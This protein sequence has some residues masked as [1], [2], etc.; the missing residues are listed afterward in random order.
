[1]IVF[2]RVHTPRRYNGIL[3]DN[4]GIIDADNIAFSGMG[5]RLSGL[6]TSSDP[7]RSFSSND[8]DAHSPATFTEYK[9]ICTTD[10]TGT[11]PQL[12]TSSCNAQ[13]SLIYASTPTASH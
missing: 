1:M 8:S 6:H 3:V 4:T 11:L 13:C 5:A 2:V 9:Y 7:K 12:K 10:D